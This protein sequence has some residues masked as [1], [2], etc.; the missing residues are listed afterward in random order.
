MIVDIVANTL[1]C[2]TS[3]VSVAIKDVDEANWKK[4]VWDKDIVP[5]KKYF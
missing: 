3:S 5:D 4:E 1:G 2:K